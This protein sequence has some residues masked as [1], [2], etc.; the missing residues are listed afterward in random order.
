MQ[1]PNGT[2]GSHLWKK[3]LKLTYFKTLKK[4]V[5]IITH[6]YEKKLSNKVKSISFD[7]YLSFLNK[8]LSLSV[9]RVRHMGSC[10]FRCYLIRK[11]WPKFMFKRSCEVRLLK[12]CHHNF[13]L[14]FSEIQHSRGNNFLLES[15]HFNT[16]TLSAT[17]I[18]NSASTV[19]S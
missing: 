6:G 10:D 7:H 12:H 1:L 18:L 4:K 8:L 15:F 17:L 16:E 2:I 9:N 5:I 11:F 13:C 3:W 19:K 14:Y